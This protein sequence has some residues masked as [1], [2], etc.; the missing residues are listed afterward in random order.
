MFFHQLPAFKLKKIRQSM[1]LSLIDEIELGSKNGQLKLSILKIFINNGNFTLP[2]LGKEMELSVPTTTKLVAELID[3]G[4]IIDFGK[5]E[6]SGG[7]R[8]NIYGLNPDSGCFL[9]VDIKK[10]RINLAIINFKGEVIESKNS[11]PFYYENSIE[12][13]NSLCQ[14][15]ND[16]VE[17]LS[18][19]KSKILTANVNMSGRINTETGHSY[20]MYYFNENPITEIFHERIGIHTTIDNDSRAMAFGEYMS[21]RVGDEKNILFVNCSWGLG[22]GIIINGNLYYGKSGFSGEF[23]HF[24]VFDNDVI[25]HCGKK[26]CLETQ[27]S[28]SYIQR[29]FL[30]KMNEGYSSSLDINKKNGTPINHEDILNAAMQEDMLA[31]ELIE[32]V[33]TTIGKY[34][35]GLIN[36]FNPELVIIGGTVALTGDYLLLPIKSAVKKYSLNFVSKDTII[37]A[38]KLGDEAGVIGACLLARSKMLGLI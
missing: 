11:V 26:G 38:S 27:A 22:L 29:R 28:G 20:S 32:E 31:I 9:G 8:P 1:K 33:G 15:I 5:A 13:F 21:G 3:E 14:I 7:R 10:Y 25:C 37:R 30:E 23:G 4:Y 6:T 34:L 2:E 24:S 12:S 17:S 16:Y 36:L 19:P 35:A 18:I